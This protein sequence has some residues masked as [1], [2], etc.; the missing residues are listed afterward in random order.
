MKK[1]TVYQH[2]NPLTL[3]TFYVGCCATIE[4][5]QHSSFNFHKG[6]LYNLYIKNNNLGIKGLGRDW[7]KLNIASVKLATFDDECEA[8]KFQANYI[9]SNYGKDGFKL[10]DIVL[11]GNAKLKPIRPLKRSSVMNLTT[12]EHYY[13]LQ[14]MV[15]AVNKN[16]SSLSRRAQR[17]INEPEYL[18]K[19]GIN[20]VFCYKN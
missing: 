1:F 12:N 15:R 10:V 3:D 11:N 17:L 4:L 6:E 20:P 5:D 2:I 19:D 18:Y 7:H 14:A 13:N 9:V 8:V 16:I